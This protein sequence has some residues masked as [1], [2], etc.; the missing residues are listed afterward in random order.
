[1]ATDTLPTLPSTAKLTYLAEGGANVVYQVD[2]PYDPERA[3]GDDSNGPKTPPP[4]ELESWQVDEPGWPHQAEGTV[5]R[6]R[7]GVLHARSVVEAEKL[8]D[9]HV[10][11]LFKAE[12]LI[13]QHLVRVPENVHV[14]LN[15]QLKQAE[16]DGTREEARRASYL[17]NDGYGLILQNMN[18][19]PPGTQGVTL[20]LKPKWLLQ[21]PNAPLDAKRCR[22]CALM[23]M[24]RKPQGFCPLGLASG[25][26]AE[27][28][29]ALKPLKE[30]GSMVRNEALRR[31]V[32]EQIAASS[33]DGVIAQIRAAQ[34]R[35]DTRGALGVKEASDS[36]LA[37]MTIRD[38]T[39][40]IRVGSLGCIQRDANI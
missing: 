23:A 40:Y 5:L 37:A 10:A 21:S 33:R 15:A 39:L 36:L 16:N 12:H 6:L 20:E 2:I 4:S 26:A 19:W 9:K 27:V 24:R 7:K 18:Y 13:T 11:P 25:N 22:T 17:R 29:R 8:F 3:S 14:S 30:A 34:Q 1:M 35:L 28:E 31:D 32:V 38:C